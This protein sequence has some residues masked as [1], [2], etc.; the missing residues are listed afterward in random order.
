[1]RVPLLFIAVL[2]TVASAALLRT[3]QDQEASTPRTLVQHDRHE[4]HERP[5]RGYLVDDGMIA[6]D[7]YKPSD[8]AA[9]ERIRN[10]INAM[11]ACRPGMLEILDGDLPDEKK[12]EWLTHYL[13]LRTDG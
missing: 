12:T 1:M 13:L 5:Q 2:A 3:R 9:R 4:R 8:P 11:P 10:T 7:I 6:N